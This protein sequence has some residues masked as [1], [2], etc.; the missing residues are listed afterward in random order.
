MGVVAKTT[1]GHT[2]R[3]KKRIRFEAKTLIKWP[4]LAL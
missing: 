2:V 1:K 3:L 4:S